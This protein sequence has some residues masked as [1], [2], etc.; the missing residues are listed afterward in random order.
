MK[1]RHAKYDAMVLAALTHAS[2]TDNNFTT[3]QKN[4]LDGISASADVNR[5]ISDSVASTSSGVTASSKAVKT[6][7]DKGVEALNKA[8]TKA[9]TSHTHAISAITSLQ[10]TLNAKLGIGAKAVDSDKL[11]GLNSTDF[12][13]S[14]GKAVDSDKLDGVDGASFMRQRSVANMDMSV[15]HYFR[16][17][18]HSSGYFVGSY[19]SVGANSAKTNPIYTI[20][21]SYKPSDTSLGNM[22]GI[23]YASSI[24]GT[25]SG[26]PAGWGMYVCANGTVDAVLNST[27]WARLGFKVGTNTVWHAGNDGAGSG[28]DADKLDGLEL[29]ATANTVANKVVRTNGSGYIYSGW[30]NTISGVTTAT[31][32]NIY[33]ETGSDKFLRKCTPTH[34]KNQLGIVAAASPTITTWGAWYTTAPYVLPLFRK[35]GNIS[36]SYNTNKQTVN[37]Y[38]QTANAVGLNFS[39]AVKCVII[40]A[41]T[42]QD[43][44]IITAYPN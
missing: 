31:I 29:G 6:A 17:Y 34:L 41:K 24:W 10:T 23:G 8:N 26:K 16:R 32:T 25:A 14:T 15:N 11:D 37:F 36:V 40:K 28:L 7:H 9:N 19:N 18:S 21:D 27:I 13:R 44:Q 30:I 42:L 35:F 2:Q 20:G 3:A 5:A 43:N 4:K 12:L 38:A 39:Q 22:Y 1:K 33:V